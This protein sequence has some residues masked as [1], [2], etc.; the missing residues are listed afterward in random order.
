MVIDRTTEFIARIALNL[1]GKTKQEQ[2]AAIR[3]Y[4]NETQLA[5]FSALNT[6]Q[7]KRAKQKRS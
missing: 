2:L 3:N 1:S 7:E 6:I 5:I 4:P